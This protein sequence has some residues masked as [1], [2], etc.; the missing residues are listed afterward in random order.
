M[1]NKRSIKELYESDKCATTKLAS[2]TVDVLLL[3]LCRII[4]DTYE[5]LLNKSEFD[6]FVSHF[7]KVFSFGGAMYAT[8]EVA[9]PTYINK[10]PMWKDCFSKATDFK[11]FAAKRVKVD[12]TP[13]SGRLGVAC[14]AAGARVTNTTR[15]HLR[16]AR[17]MST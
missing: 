17:I 16:T 1:D 4:R 6:A 14:S 9:K 5:K 7:E 11:R 13:R 15:T 2:N 12:Q 3:E 10:Y 8:W